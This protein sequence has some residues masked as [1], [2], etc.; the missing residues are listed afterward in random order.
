MFYRYPNRHDLPGSVKQE[1]AMASDDAAKWHVDITEFMKGGV[2]GSADVA[3]R[4]AE[5]ILEYTQDAEMLEQQRPLT[6]EDR[7]DTWFILGSWNRDKVQPGF[8]P[9]QMTVKKR[10]AQVLDLGMPVVLPALS[11]R[12]GK[13]T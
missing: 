4:F 2:L 10:D 3:R 5:L 6:V 12:K 11:Q 1:S 9:F 8:G 7:G 13:P